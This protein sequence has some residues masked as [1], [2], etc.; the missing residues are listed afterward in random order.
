MFSKEK[1][2][3]S[4]SWSCRVNWIIT[5]QLTFPTTWWAIHTMVSS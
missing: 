5:H 4:Q 2:I 1:H 3:P